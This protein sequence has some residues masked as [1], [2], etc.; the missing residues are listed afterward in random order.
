MKKQIILIGGAPTI[1]KSFLAKKLSEK[2]KI[3]WISTDTIRKFMREVVRE[4]DYSNLFYFT[5]KTAKNYLTSHT[6]EQIVKD[7]NNESIDVWKGVK[8]FISSDYN[9]QFYIIEGVAVLPRFISEDLSDNKSIRSIFLLNNNEERIKKIIFKRGLWS[10]SNKYPDNLKSIEVKWVIKFN[11]WLKKELK[12]YK[13]PLIEFNGDDI[14]I[15][16]VKK[17]L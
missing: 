14:P 6:P 15:S 11:A 8:S 4:K 9:W 3:P 2:M 12:K 16:E 7:Q 17:Y 13:Y 1:G 10:N 5:K